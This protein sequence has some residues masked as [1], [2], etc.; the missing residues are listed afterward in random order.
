MRATR[1]PV[2][3]ARPPSL[4]NIEALRVYFTLCVVIRHMLAEFGW[5]GAGGVISVHFF[6]IL[7][8]YLLVLSY[9]PERSI[10]E[11]A[12]QRYIRFVPLVIFGGMLNFGEWRSFEGIFMLQA[13]G[14]YPA[15]I[16][17]GPAWYIGVLF[18][19]TLLYIGLMH[20]LSRK[21]F[22]M[23]VS[24][25]LFLSTLMVSHAPGNIAELYGGIVPKGMLR[26][27]ACMAFGIL[28]AYFI[29]RNTNE[30]IPPAQRVVY[31]IAELALLSY[32]SVA[33]YNIRAFSNIWITQPLYLCA[34]LYLFI[35]K[36]GYISSWLE[37]TFY[38]KIAKYCLAV[39]LTHVCFQ[40]MVKISLISEHSQWVREHATWVVI[41]AVLASCI[42]GVLAHHFIEKPCTRYLS[43]FFN[44][45]SPETKKA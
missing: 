17:N 20:T 14:L 42:V 27:T 32:I 18:C 2:R 24:I 31:T 43:Q 38:S 22:M 3:L 4:I 19:L 9:R 41:L 13:T 29:R 7:S 10:L 34:L 39:Y 26:G 30:I 12:K 5:W 21:M 45:L 36:R 28:I 16:P 35:V 8:G 1:S 25:I 6:F 33:M 23:T 11:I 44:W 15:E 40:K 37:H